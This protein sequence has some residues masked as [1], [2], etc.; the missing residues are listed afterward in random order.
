MT[1][2]TTIASGA[3]LTPDSWLSDM[4]DRAVWRF[5]ALEAVSAPADLVPPG[6]GPAFAWGRVPLDCAGSGNAPLDACLD[7]GYRP[8][9]VSVTLACRPDD[10]LCPPVR[11]ARVR[12]AAPG[13]RRAVIEIARSA[14]TRSRFHQ[15]RE[16]VGHAGDL[17]AAWADA[18]FRGERGSAMSVAEVDGR[19][20]GF[21]TTLLVDGRTMVID[22]VAVEQGARGCGIAALLTSHA[23]AGHADVETMLVGTQLANRAAVGSYLRMGFQLG[24]AAYAMHYHRGST[25]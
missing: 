10:L 2:N 5:G 1:T 11:D 12:D 20:V 24:D 9:E 15:D 13:D 19:V 22:L 7:A 18:F 4:L 25:A 6:D 16:L 17:K 21:L 14:F 3:L 23:R 8:A